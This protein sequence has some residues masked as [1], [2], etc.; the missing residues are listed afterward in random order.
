MWSDLGS[1]WC[2]RSLL[3]VVERLVTVHVKVTLYRK[4]QVY[5]RLSQIKIEGATSYWHI[6]FFSPAQGVDPVSV[7]WI[8]N[9][10]L[11]LLLEILNSDGLN[12]NEYVLSIPVFS[13]VFYEQMWM[14]LELN[15]SLMFL[16]FTSQ[17]EAILSVLGSDWFL[18]FLQPHL[19]P[20][21]V[22]LA[23]IFLTHFLSSPSQKSSFRE[24]VI[25]ATFIECMEDPLAV[26][27]TRFHFLKW[28]SDYDAHI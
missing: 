2:T 22:K 27:G 3:L 16:S 19:H 17:Q 20:S 10:M 5:A 24:G 4:P 7:V 11:L 21:T 28:I 18:L 26:I 9:Q 25:P 13:G 6:F 8:R 1:S 23:L 14:I 12:A 15:Q